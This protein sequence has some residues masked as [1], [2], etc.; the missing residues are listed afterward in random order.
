MTSE[1]TSEVIFELSGLNYPCSHAS[2]GF[3]GFPEMIETDGRTGP[4]MIHRLACFAAG[5]KG[6]TGR[7]GGEGSEAL[8]QINCLE[9]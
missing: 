3:K 8:K 1:V 4:I 6:E 2:L 7:E 9:E 5:K